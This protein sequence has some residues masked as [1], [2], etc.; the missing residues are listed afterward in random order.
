M[1]QTHSLPSGGGNPILPLDNIS[2]HQVRFIPG[3][4]PIFITQDL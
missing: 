4:H 2:G 1:P 3:K